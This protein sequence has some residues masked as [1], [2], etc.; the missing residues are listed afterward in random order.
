MDQLER[1]K[2]ILSLRLQVNYIAN[3]LQRKYCPSWILLDD[4]IQWGWI[5]AIKAV[6][7]FNSNHNPNHQVQLK[8][9]AEYRIRGEIL[10]QIRKD[11]RY[12][13]KTEDLPINISVRDSFRDIKL[14]AY[15]LHKKAN[16]G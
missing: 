1:E 13:S 7:N 14:T 5:G 4:L 10:D 6:D 16:I 3:T 2:Q 11:L 12:S 8:T 15:F 9:Y